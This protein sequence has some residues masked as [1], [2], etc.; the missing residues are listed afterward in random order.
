M[1][2]TIRKN[3]KRTNKRKNKRVLTHKKKKHIGGFFWDYNEPRRFHKFENKDNYKDIRFSDQTYKMKTNS[4]GHLGKEGIRNNFKLAS[5]IINDEPE[6]KLLLFAKSIDSSIYSFYPEAIFEEKLEEILN[7]I[8]IVPKLNKE[9]LNSLKLELKHVPEYP[10]PVPVFLKDF[11][12][13]MGEDQMNVN[14]IK[15][16]KWHMIE[17]K[18]TLE[19]FLEARLSFFSRD[20]K[21]GPDSVPPRARK[22]L[23]EFLKDVGLGKFVSAFH[24]YGIDRFSDLKGILASSDE[25]FKEKFGMEKEDIAKLRTVR[26]APFSFYVASKF[27]AIML[28]SKEIKVTLRS[29]SEK[30]YLIMENTGGKNELYIKNLTDADHLGRG[31]I[32]DEGIVHNKEEIEPRERKNLQEFMSQIALRFSD[33]STLAHNMFDKSIIAKERVKCDDD[34][35]R[36]RRWDLD[37][38]IDNN[39]SSIGRTGHHRGL[40]RR[41]GT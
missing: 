29:Q 39:K 8:I 22:N 31:S 13:T 6:R 23:L 33:G 36:C 14:E 19:A 40:T 28:K 12:E 16:D 26:T 11:V 32:F 24:E 20:A 41:Q 21:V 35:G 10:V 38:F 2:K 27:P 3:K 37:T 17:K 18:E 7:P 4:I 15:W 1:N 30:M 5:Y 25:E 9:N 34:E